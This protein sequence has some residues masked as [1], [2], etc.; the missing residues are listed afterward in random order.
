MTDCSAKRERSWRVQ[1]CPALER[2]RNMSQ[3]RGALQRWTRLRR[4]NAT[5]DCCVVVYR[6]N[7]TELPPTQSDLMMM[8]TVRIQRTCHDVA[9][10]LSTTYDKEVTT[11]PARLNR[12]RM[13]FYDFLIRVYHGKASVNSTDGVCLQ[14]FGRKGIRPVKT[15]WWV[16]AWLSVWSEVQ[17]CIWPS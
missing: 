5:N 8:K 10:S 15:E 2:S 16:L 7:L 3:K 14:C 13:C 4:A 11:R 17:T 9:R 6:S 1:I 12:S